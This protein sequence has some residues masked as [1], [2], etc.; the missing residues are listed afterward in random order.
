MDRIQHSP[1]SSSHGHG[2]DRQDEEDIYAE[3]PTAESADDAV[4]IR[5]SRRRPLGI[6]QNSA[7]ALDKSS[8]VTVTETSSTTTTSMSKRTAGP[9]EINYR[10]NYEPYVTSTIERYLER[11]QTNLHTK[12]TPLPNYA[13]MTPSQRISALSTVDDL[14]DRLMTRSTSSNVDSNSNAVVGALGVGRY[15]QQQLDDSVTTLGV[16]ELS[17]CNDQ[18]FGSASTTLE[19]K[20][21]CNETHGSET[22][23]GGISRESTGSSERE[24]G[25]SQ[26]LEESMDLLSDDDC[27]GG[28]GNNSYHAN[29]EEESRFLE[30]ENAC[31]ESISKLN[32]PRH[33]DNSRNTT[34]SPIE[35]ARHADDHNN[36]SRTLHLAFEDGRN[37]LDTST[38][39]P[40]F[41]QKHHPSKRYA[42]NS[43]KRGLKARHRSNHPDCVDDELL[44]GHTDGFCVDENNTGIYQYFQD[45]ESPIQRRFTN[46][47]VDFDCDYEMAEDNEATFN[48]MNG[49]TGDIRK[50]SSNLDSEAIDGDHAD[51][52]PD[53]YDNNIDDDYSDGSD[54][55]IGGK[56]IN[57]VPSVMHPQH[58]QWSTFRNAN[59]NL[60]SHHEEDTDN[61]DSPVR[62]GM[63]YAGESQHTSSMQQSQAKNHEEDRRKGDIDDN[64]PIQTIRN[65]CRRAQCLE[66]QGLD[67][68]QEVAPIDVR[69]RDG[70]NFRIDPLQCRTDKRR[71]NTSSDLSLPERDSCKDPIS[72]FPSRVSARLNAGVHFL[73]KKER[74]SLSTITSNIE[75]EDDYPCAILLSMTI[76]QILCVTSK[77]L[78]Q[79]SQS[80]KNYQLSRNASSVKHLTPSLESSSK[81]GDYLAGGTLIVLREKEDIE[82][83]EVALR[84]NTSLSVLSKWCDV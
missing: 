66:L 74:Q 43:G 46:D 16:G 56:S 69:V 71:N 44:G 59:A 70:M 5:S 36:Y 14:L 68:L 39:P 62:R 41:S 31:C 32:N 20:Q 33:D 48:A 76:H 75:S 49:N 22:I 73:I 12:G 13:D 81:D 77:L 25:I 84:E 52:S 47:G 35:R 83:W 63:L 79:T 30:E 42:S 28:A 17:H 3:P 1:S 23:V 80:T 6:V 21:Y 65:L 57:L 78:I 58:S 54:G 4:C 67:S 27:G 50:R 15:E 51:F 45:D 29:D 2:S 82:Q 26:L 9:N 19:P 34:T 24:N 38:T 11:T 40:V 7:C 10:R 64:D 55:G 37:I 72:D 8:S 60:T 18:T 53:N 61:D